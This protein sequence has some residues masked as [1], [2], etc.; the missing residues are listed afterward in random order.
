[1]FK[2]CHQ[3]NVSSVFE[4]VFHA[5]HFYRAIQSQDVREIRGGGRGPQCQELDRVTVLALLLLCMCPR[6]PHWGQDVRC[7]Q[8]SL[9][10]SPPLAGSVALDCLRPRQGLTHLLACCRSPVNSCT[11]QGSPSLQTE[12]KSLLTRSKKDS[13]AVAMGRRERRDRVTAGLCSHF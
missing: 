1:M 2:D 6:L 9:G 3:D 5:G 7:S 8:S 13:V 4:S 12:P 10:V 11:L